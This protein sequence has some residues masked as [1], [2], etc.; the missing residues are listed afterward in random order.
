MPGP[1]TPAPARPPLLTLAHPPPPSRC[2]AVSLPHPPF[3]MAPKSKSAATNGAS[4][5]A[6]PAASEVAATPSAPAPEPVSQ[7]FTYATYGPGKPDKATYD[8]EQNKIK[9]EIDALQAK[10]VRAF[11]CALPA[12]GNFMS[13]CLPRPA[14]SRPLCVE[15]RAG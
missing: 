2:I 12:S 13:T 8:A 15:R 5:K 4:K 7:E 6:Q 9:A 10:L 14:P 3:A 11:G 1:P